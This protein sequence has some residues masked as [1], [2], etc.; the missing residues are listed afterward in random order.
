MYETILVL[1]EAAKKRMFELIKD[2][3]LARDSSD[4]T[5]SN[6][7]KYIFKITQHKHVNTLIR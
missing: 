1:N 3:G 2:K 7:N 4:K 5:H 6:F